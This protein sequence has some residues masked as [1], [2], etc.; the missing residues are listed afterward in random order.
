M[1]PAKGQDDVDAFNEGF[2]CGI[3]IHNENALSYR[4]KMRFWDFC[5]ATLI[6][7]IGHS[8]GGYEDPHIPSVTHFA[9][10][11]GKNK[12]TSFIGM[13]P[14][15]FSIFG[16]DGLIDGNEKRGDGLQAICYGA[17]S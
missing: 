3:A 5:R 13:P 2:V 4:S 11:G 7:D 12:P 9:F 1:G 15:F 17:L 10:Y 8:W 16:D 14:V 6:E